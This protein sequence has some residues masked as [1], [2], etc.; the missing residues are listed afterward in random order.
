MDADIVCLS[1][2]FRKLTWVK[3]LCTENTAGK[4]VQGLCVLEY[5]QCKVVGAVFLSLVC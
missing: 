1:K 2:I 5:A 4:E 3:D